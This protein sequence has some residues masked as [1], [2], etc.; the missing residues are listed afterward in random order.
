MKVL[1]K[2]LCAQRYTKQLNSNRP[3]GSRRLDGLQMP[4]GSSYHWY[5]SLCNVVQ[6]Q[7]PSIPANR[8][9]TLLKTSPQP[10]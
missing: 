5:A 1:L 2:S 4:E 9:A 6:D 3:Y 7:A 8:A 10:T